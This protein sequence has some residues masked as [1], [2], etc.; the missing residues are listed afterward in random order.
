MSPASFAS[1]TYTPDKLFA[2]HLPLGQPK[3]ITLLSGEAARL[4]GAVLGRKT[5][6]AT[7]AAAVAAGAGAAGANTG[8]GIVTLAG[9]PFDGRV[10]AGNYKVTFIEP[11]T[12]LGKFVVEDPD[13]VIIGQGTVGTAFANH[14]AFTIADGAADFIAGDGFVIAVSAITHKYLRSAIAA[15]DGS[16]FPVAILAEDADAT[17]GDVEA[18]IYERGDFN[19]ASLNFGTGHTAT[20]VRE[21]LR[22]RGVFLVAVQAS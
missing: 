6:A 13:G 18:L 15:V 7:V 14:I 3:K 21:M 10:K 22:S 19:E 12:D 2:G 1:S 17:S 11:A 9:T 5:T 8:D 4:R 16:A 20:T